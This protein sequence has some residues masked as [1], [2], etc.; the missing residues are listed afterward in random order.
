MKRTSLQ[1]VVLS[2]ALVCS[3]FTVAETGKAYMFYDKSEPQV[4]PDGTMVQK[5]TSHGAFHLTNQPEGFPSTMAGR[6]E[7]VWVMG[8][9]NSNKGSTFTCI[10]E[11]NDGGGYMNV[12][13]ITG[14]DWSGCS[15]KT[16]SG[17]GKYAGASVSGTCQPT[18]PFAGADTGSVTWAGEWTLPE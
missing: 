18:G 1:L 13:F 9:D 7:D 12:G 10:V 3:G 8:A 14:A 4:M 11:D 5:S 17:W 15:F 6:C 2:V 16:V